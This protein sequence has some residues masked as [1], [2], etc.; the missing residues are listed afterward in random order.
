[1][2]RS[3]VFVSEA[4]RK[5]EGTTDVLRD[6]RVQAIGG[7]VERNVGGKTFLLTSDSQLHVL[8]N[9]SAATLWEAIRDAGPEGITASE[10][11]D[12][13]VKSFVV[14]HRQ[15]REDVDSF[16]DHLV[17]EAVIREAQ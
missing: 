13:L 8:D 16:L 5:N 14:D 15:A 3:E 2:E 4:D 17:R 9:V 12:L 7:L 1:M 10:M 6:R 11:A